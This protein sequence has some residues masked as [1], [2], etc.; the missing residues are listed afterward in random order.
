MVSA[1]TLSDPS[2]KGPD[3]ALNIKQVIIRIVLIVMMVD[4]MI[5]ELFSVIPTI[6]DT[7]LASLLDAAVLVAVSAPLIYV[8]VI[9]PFITAHN[10]AVSQITHMAHHDPLTQ[11]PNRRLLSESLP[12]YLAS[13]TR[14]RAHG[15]LLFIDLD[16][17]KSVNDNYGHD[18]GDKVLVE[19]AKR[20]QSI[21]QSEDIVSRIGG[22][23]FVLMI[24][25]LGPDEHKA[26]K[27][28][29]TVAKL[30][31]KSLERPTIFENTKLQVS[32]SIGIRLLGS[33][34]LGEE[35]AIRDADN[36]MYRA[37]HAG[38]GRIVFFAGTD[39]QKKRAG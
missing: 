3:R 31:Q 27:K 32:S 34:Q 9:K 2:S 5:V 15:A 1:K 29:K 6:L 18:A 12:R 30:L 26:Y 25:G 28:A 8:W 16:G 14:H 17:L 35:D 13:C 11:L 21:T 20:L 23:E 39:A 38:G 10:N 7:R 22:D 24:Q 19:T 37:K 33:N 4:F 36:A